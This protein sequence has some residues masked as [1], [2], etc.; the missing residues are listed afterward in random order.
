MKIVKNIKGIS[1]S[2]F[3]L[4]VGTEACNSDFLSVPAPAAIAETQLQNK[5]GVE[6]M[7]VGAY[8]MLLGRGL[9][10]IFLSG[11]TNWF[12]GSVQGGDANKGSESGD[13]AVMNAGMRYEMTASH[14]V[15][16]WKWQGCYEAIARANNVLKNVGK[17]ADMSDADKKRVI[18]EARFLRGHSY[19]ELQKHFNKVPYIDET[20]AEP[21]KV[22]NSG[23]VWDKIEAD[24]NTAYTTLPETQAAAGRANKWAAGAYLAKALLFQKKFDAAATLFEAVIKDGQTTNG[25][26]YGLAA[27]FNDVFNMDTEN[28]EEHVFSVQAAAGTGTANNT[29]TDYVLNF[30][31]TSPAVGCCGFFQPSFDM[32]NS[33]RTDANGLP[34]LDNSYNTAANL[35]K[36]DQ[37]IASAD[38]FTLDA[39]QLDPRLDWTVGRRGIP[40]YDW[41]D[42]P[43]KAWIRAQENAGPYSPKK[44]M[45][46]KAQFGSL[47]DGSSWTRGFTA[48]NYPL[49]RFAD[50][51]LMAAEAHVEKATPDLAKALDYVNRVRNRAANPAGFVMKGAAP[52]ANY[53]IKPYT[54]FADQPTARAAVRMERKLELS[55]EG[56]RF[57]DLVRWGVAKAELDRYLANDAAILTDRLGGASFKAGKNEYW[58]IPQSQIDLEGSSVLTQNPGY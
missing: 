30:T 17:A 23:T 49:L 40:Y 27:K 46:T 53:V 50:V 58:P 41:Q 47:T 51:L 32:V 7:L 8:S 22:P 52:A 21:G 38:A 16:D 33:Y 26:K 29:Q 3:F 57:Y 18:G 42:H 24:L 14:Q 4:V 28:N 34:L 12:A 56:H 37:G 25:K 6:G 20:T 35:V 11:S 31:Y 2:L 55:Q 19:F 1:L 48:I 44:F 54:T 36:H 43:G 45:M 39:G 15:P 5:D 10:N 9:T 13:A